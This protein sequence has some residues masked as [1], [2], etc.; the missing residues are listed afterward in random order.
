MRVLVNHS[1]E[2]SDVICPWCS[3]GMKIEQS[4]LKGFN[5]LVRDF[6]RG[7]YKREYYMKCATCGNDMV[8]NID[9]VMCVGD[10]YRDE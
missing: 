5:Y 7:Y 6:K 2:Q 3:D 8:V 10:V 1:G 9:W 4:D